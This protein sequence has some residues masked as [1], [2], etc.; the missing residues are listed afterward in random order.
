MKMDTDR[1]TVQER[2]IHMKSYGKKLMTLA[3]LISALCFICTGCGKMTAEKLTDKVDEALEGRTFIGM[4][5]DL[6]MD[7]SYSMEVLSQPVSA[8]L[9]MHVNGRS[10]NNY[11]PL[12]IYTDMNTRMDFQMEMDGEVQNMSMEDQI[13]SYSVQEDGTFA[14]YTYSASASQW[15]RI[16]TDLSAAESTASYADALSGFLAVPEGQQ[17]Q[18]VLEEETVSLNGTE[19]YVFKM[20]HISIDSDYLAIL[21]SVLPQAAGAISGDSLEDVTISATCYIDQETFLPLQLD[22][23]FDNFGELFNQNPELWESFLGSSME[24]SGTGNITI[25]VPLFQASMTN[26]SFEP[27]EL[28][29]VPEE[30]YESIAFQ[31]ALADLEPDLGDGTYAIQY[32]GSAV[33]ISTPEGM[34]AADTATDTLTFMDASGM[35]TIAYSMVPAVDLEL[36]TDS[37]S[38]MYTSMLEALG[39]TVQSG[40]DSQNVS[41]P[42]GP[43]DGYW[44]S[45]GGVSVYYGFAPFDGAYLAVIRSE[46]SG[47]EPDSGAALGEA[48]GY[49]AELTPADI[50]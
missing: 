11:D 26:L 25:D 38:S 42:F 44:I 41:T 1:F 3:A 33:R 32:M 5:M 18:V 15:S 27:E 35:N 40:Q 4:D 28:P 31:E 7:A 21:E 36:Y 10:L 34:S 49:A 47:T 43:V 30:A 20:D 2:G 48:F 12:G 46:F 9:S 19:A 24:A 45:G 22:Y 39:V 8:S 14:V 50:L 23:T 13:Q 16:E 6:S 37:I 29:V 17:E